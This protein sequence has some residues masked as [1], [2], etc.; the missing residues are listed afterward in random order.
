MYTGFGVD[1]FPTPLG[2]YQGTQLLAY[3]VSML[4]FG[5]GHGNPLQLV[6]LPGESHGQRSLVGCNTWGR[7]ESDVA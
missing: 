1:M 3:T 4:S 6:L 2:K 5:E 7:G